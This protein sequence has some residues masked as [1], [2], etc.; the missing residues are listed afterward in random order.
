MRRRACYGHAAHTFRGSGL[1][2]WLAQVGVAGAVLLQN[3]CVTTGPAEWIQNGFKVGTNYC[4]TPAPVAEEWI[5]AKDSKVQSRRLQ[6]EDWWNVFRDPYLN[7]LIQTAYAQN[8]TLRI[9]GTRVL[10]ARAQQAIAV[11]N[12]FPQTQQATG[13]YSRVNLSRNAP[14][15]PVALVRVLRNLPGAGSAFSQAPSN[16]LPTNFYS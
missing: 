3:G 10:Q 8:L 16:V 6:D 5:E 15:N 7:S 11:G 1:L 13:Q 9:V 2:S 4:R 14:T 12:F